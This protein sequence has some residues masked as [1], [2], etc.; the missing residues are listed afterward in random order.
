MHYFLVR[1][2]VEDFDC[3]NSVVESPGEAQQVSGAASAV[4][5]EKEEHNGVQR[6]LVTQR[7]AEVSGGFTGS[8]RRCCRDWHHSQ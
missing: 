7:M 1:Q 4:T 3:W 8:G 6:C 5:E 2:K